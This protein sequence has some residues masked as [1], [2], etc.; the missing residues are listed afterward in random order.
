MAELVAVKLQAVG[1]APRLKKTRIDVPGDKSF[2]FVIE[3]LRQWTRM[4]SIFVFINQSFAPAPNV[5]LA[6]LYRCFQVNNALQ[7]SYCDKL[8]WG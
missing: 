5:T 8:A 1:G 2:A 6:D 7:V 3:Q 4:D